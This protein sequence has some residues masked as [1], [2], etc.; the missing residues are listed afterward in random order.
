MTALVSC[1]F[2]LLPVLKLPIKMEGIYDCFGSLRILAFP[3]AKI[4]H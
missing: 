1:E 2:W 4:A 3:I